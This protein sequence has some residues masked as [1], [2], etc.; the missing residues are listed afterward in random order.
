MDGPLAVGLDERPFELLL[1][2]E[3]FGCLNCQRLLS[4]PYLTQAIVMPCHAKP[5][6][7][8]T[9]MLTNNFLPAFQTCKIGYITMHS[10]QLS[11]RYLTR[12]QNHIPAFNFLQHPLALLL[13]ASSPNRTSTISRC[14]PP[15]SQ[16][17]TSQTKT[18][19]PTSP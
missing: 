13:W 14:P 6:S 16:A 12:L 2:Q 4:I 17:P 18:S 8:S 11:N 19:R 1:P 7:S 15:Q 5:C 9:P 3:F 10:S